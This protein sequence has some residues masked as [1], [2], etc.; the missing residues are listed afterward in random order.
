SGDPGG[1][2]SNAR[3]NTDLTIEYQPPRSK[4]T[5][6]IQALGLFNNIYGYPQYNDCY[7]PV[8]TG[9]SGPASGGPTPNTCANSNYSY[10]NGYNGRTN[11]RG[12]SPYLIIPNNNFGFTSA[13]T[14]TP[15]LT[16]FYVQVKL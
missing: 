12:T 7:Q 14:Q 10:G 1:I 8:A 5:F 6:G 9:V 13:S 4:V 16:L 2:L 3:F 11:I 15:L